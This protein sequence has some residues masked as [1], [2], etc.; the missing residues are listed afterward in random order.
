M[1]KEE[2]GEWGNGER[3]RSR[4]SRKATEFRKLCGRDDDHL[5]VFF[6]SGTNDD[7]T[8]GEGKQVDLD[9]TCGIWSMHM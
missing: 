5:W 3:D 9:V 7:K 1:K 6:A 2:T 8:M 4:Y